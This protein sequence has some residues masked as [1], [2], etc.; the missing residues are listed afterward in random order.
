MNEVYISKLIR[1]ITAGL[2][3]V[4]DIKDLAYKSEVENR[5]A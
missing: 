3:T 4:A 5:L 1:L 2:I